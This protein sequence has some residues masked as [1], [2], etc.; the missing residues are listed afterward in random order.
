MVELADIFRLHGSEYLGKHGQSM[1]PSQKEA[2]LN[3]MLCRTPALGGSVYQCH[4][5]PK[6]DYSYHSCK[7][8]ACPKC[9]NDETS[10]WIQRQNALL[11]PSDYFLITTTLPHVFNPLAQN[12]QRKIYSSF[13]YQSAQAILTLVRDPRF[14]GGQTGFVGV[15]QTW[16]SRVRFH[17]H[18]HFLVPAGALSD[19]ARSWLRPK[20]TDFLIHETPLGILLKGKFKAA[21]TKAGLSHV[22]SP[23]AWKKPWFPDC[24]FIGPAHH[25]IKYLAP[26]IY[27]VAISNNRIETLHDGRVTFR[28]KNRR[29]DTWERETIPALEFM[30][31]FLQHVLPKGFQKV[32][33]YGLLHPKKRDLLNRA[34]ELLGAMPYA[35]P[36]KKTKDPTKGYRNCPHCGGKLFLLKAL[37]PERQRGPP[38]SS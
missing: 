27:R 13:M 37:K 25:A 24:Q 1:L 7:N 32:R 19:D 36:Q 6:Q 8:R 31:R 38:C 3:I 15:L 11:F 33:Y 20:G 17:L 4:D 16:D 28:Y 30:G 12:H 18:V 34:R 14:V 5:C 10:A 26:Y 22:V 2:L 9:R 23:D 21:V 35:K 29:T